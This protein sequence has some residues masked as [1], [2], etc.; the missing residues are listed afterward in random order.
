[1]RVRKNFLESKWGF[2]YNMLLKKA[3]RNSSFVTIGQVVNLLLGLLFAGMTIRYLGTAVAGFFIIAS[4][5]LVWAQMAGG[6]SFQGPSILKLAQYFVEKDW[7][8]SKDLLRTV[9]SANLIISLPFAL[10]SIIAFPILFSW[11]RLEL[12]Y[13]ED[14]LIVVI[15]ISLSFVL[16]QWSFGLKAVYEGHNRFDISSYNSIFFGIAGNL[17]KL[18]ILIIFRSMVE[19]ALVSLIISSLKMMT[20][21]IIV[22]HLIGSVIIPGWKKGVLRPL[23]SFGIWSWIGNT[24]NVIFYNLTNLLVA[25]SLG[26][27]AL[28]YVAL[29]QN[30]VFQI[31][32]FISSSAYFLFPTLAAQ[33]NS[34][35]KDIIR[36]EDR[37]RWFI[38]LISFAI[39]GGLFL[40]GPWF[41]RIIVTQDYAVKAFLPLAIYC[42]FG[43]ASTQTLVNTFSTMA[44]GRINANVLTGLFVSILAL[45]TTVVLLPKVGYIGICIAQLWNIPGTV[46][47]TIWSRKI[48]GLEKS[49]VKAWQPLFSPAIGFLLW[50]SL[51]FLF[52]FLFPDV[53]VLQVAIWLIGSLLYL[54]A[55]WIQETVFFPS[56]QRWATINRASRIIFSKIFSILKNN[57]FSQ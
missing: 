16:E 54:V 57:R 19:L 36:I 15:L 53:I 1:M 34:V 25:R 31:G 46:L 22:R 18:G 13:R 11:S 20:D 29:P 43:I 7:Q 52:Q 33:G 39:Y 21:T 10:A 38:N 2:H 12:G 9:T 17:A 44:L 51:V 8:R 35:Q 24:S 3:I 4:S 37:M 55:V 28:T 49:A 5:I 56:L 45:V 6:G 50:T 40:A 23:M 47:H 42:L 27:S 30:I 41:L 26:S 32:S 48:M 14:A